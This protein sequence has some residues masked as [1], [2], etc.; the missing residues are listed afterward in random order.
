MLQRRIKTSIYVNESFHFVTPGGEEFV[1]DSETV[2]GKFGQIW[3]HGQMTR[4]NVVSCIKFVSAD[5]SKIKVVSKFNIDDEDAAKLL[6]S[7]LGGG[8]IKSVTIKNQ[9]RNI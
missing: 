3:C 2:Y 6:L 4:L 7:L 5:A 1:I 8:S 9:R